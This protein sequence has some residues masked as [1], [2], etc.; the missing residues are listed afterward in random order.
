MRNHKKG[1]GIEDVGTDKANGPGP[2]SQFVG[3]LQ[4]CVEFVTNIEITNS[5][6]QCFFFFA[7]LKDGLI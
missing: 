5:A 2:K 1:H 4:K 3:S 6:L 7:S